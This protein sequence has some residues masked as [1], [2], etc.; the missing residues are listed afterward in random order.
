MVCMLIACMLE[1]CVNELYAH[2]VYACLLSFKL[3]GHQLCTNV[4]QV[5]L[6]L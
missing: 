1:L 2:T 6:H 4:H 5:V 3:E